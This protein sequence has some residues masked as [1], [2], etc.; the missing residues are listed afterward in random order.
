MGKKKKDKD[1][2][3]EPTDVFGGR[4]KKSDEMIQFEIRDKP[5]LIHFPEG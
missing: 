5:W 3:P 1:E 4:Y 2:E